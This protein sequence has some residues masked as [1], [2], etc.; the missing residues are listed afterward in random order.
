MH[1]SLLIEIVRPQKKNC[2][3]DRSLSL[4]KPTYF[5][6]TA[7]RT[8]LA[9]SSLAV[10]KGF[11]WRIEDRICFPENMTSLLGVWSM[12]TTDM[13]G[14]GSLCSMRLLG[15]SSRESGCHDFTDWTGLCLVMLLHET[16]PK[17][18]I[19]ASSMFS[20]TIGDADVN[21]R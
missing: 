13:Q 18:W 5:L 12:L 7:V 11:N 16:F 14:L 2:Y 6:C 1:F 20:W 4:H 21:R 17:S 8:D 3:E 9:K 15:L 10:S 19:F